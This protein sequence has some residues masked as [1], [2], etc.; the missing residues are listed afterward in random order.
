MLLSVLGNNSL[1][2]AKMKKILIAV[3]TLIAVVLLVAGGICAVGLVYMSDNFEEDIPNHVDILPNEYGTVVAVGK[4]LYDKNGN[5]FNI[6][7]INYGN[8]F[9]S[10]GWMTVNSV[11]AAYDEDG[12]FKS[13][14]YQGIVEEYDELFQEEMD[15]ILLD[16]VAKG[17]FTAEQLKTLYDTFFHF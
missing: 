17:D 13:V 10:E 5:R 4:G 11:G 2:E 7:G 6:E 16:R 15:A 12:N 3:G 14:N 1:L 9:I 8:L